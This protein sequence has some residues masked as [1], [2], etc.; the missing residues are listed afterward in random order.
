MQLQ[1]YNFATAAS[2]K[3]YFVALRRETARAGA[4]ITGF[5]NWLNL[6]KS[7]VQNAGFV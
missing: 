2:K 1:N 4:K 5:C 7:I 3:A 6:L